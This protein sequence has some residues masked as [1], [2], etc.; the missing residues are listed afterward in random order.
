LIQLIAETLV[1]PEGEEAGHG[2]W[3]YGAYAGKGSSTE[4]D[5]A[6]AEM[7]PFSFGS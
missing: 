6:L 3:C 5:F 4:A 2:L 7:R 1:T